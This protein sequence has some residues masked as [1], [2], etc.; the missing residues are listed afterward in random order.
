MVGMEII[1]FLLIALRRHSTHSNMIIVLKTTCIIPICFHAFQMPKSR[2]STQHLNKP[3]GGRIIFTP[4]H[5][6]H[7]LTSPKHIPTTP[8]RNP[9]TRKRSPTAP[10]G[11]PIRY[12]PSRCMVHSPQSVAMDFWKLNVRTI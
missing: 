1:I 10:E 5:I 4:F 11:Y 9:T 12:M 2:K 3:Q 6:T 7:I 8:K